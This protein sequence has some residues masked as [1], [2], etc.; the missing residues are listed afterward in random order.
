[1]KFGSSTSSR[2]WRAARSKEIVDEQ[3]D[4]MVRAEKFGF[5]S[6]WPAEHHFSE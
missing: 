6:V 4:V 1:M 2:T 3:I 5:D